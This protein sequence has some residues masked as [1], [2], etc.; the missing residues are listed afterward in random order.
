MAGGSAAS[1]IHSAITGKSAVPW[2]RDRMTARAVAAFQVGVR[3]IELDDVR[4]PEPRP[5]KVLLQLTA[6]GICGSDL[7]YFRTGRIGSQ[8]L[9]FPQILG[10]EPAGVAAAIG[11]RVRNI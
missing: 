1:S 2:V 3:R 11:K 6:V 10:H 5:G 4:L 7:H 9:A 8:V